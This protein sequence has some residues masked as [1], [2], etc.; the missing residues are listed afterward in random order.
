[1]THCFKKGTSINIYDGTQSDKEVK[2]PFYPSVAK[3]LSVLV[4]VSIFH[5]IGFY[6]I[7]NSHWLTNT[8]NIETPVSKRNFTL[9]LNYTSDD[10]EPTDNAVKEANKTTT[11]KRDSL[12]TTSHQKNTPLDATSHKNE[13]STKNTDDISSSTLV[14]K[15]ENVD[16]STKAPIEAQEAINTQP[17]K[18]ERQPLDVTN[19]NNTIQETFD[20]LAGVTEIKESVS[21]SDSFTI[22]QETMITPEPKKEEEFSTVFSPI[23]KSALKDA[24][25]EQK[26][27]LKG[28]IK[29]KGYPI[30]KDSD[31]TRYVNIKGICWK[32]PPEGESGEWFIVPAGCNNQKDAFHFEFGITP[33]MLG[34]NSPF[35]RLL[36][37][38]FDQNQ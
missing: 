24:I 14:L 12:A 10:T 37:L 35:S 32:M 6:I 26:Q 13:P 20:D 15:P 36:G 5:V 25:K 29:N 21:L 34:P 28:F 7:D 19:T 2:K 23:Y 1:M 3:W 17:Q 18:I 9:Q 38:E 11:I 16:I 33:E 8:S 22:A 4:T 30:T 27:Y 31:G